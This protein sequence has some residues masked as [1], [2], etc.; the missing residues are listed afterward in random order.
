MQYDVL[1]VVIM[2]SMGIGA[3]TYH[4]MLQFGDW[5]RKRLYRKHLDKIK[6]EEKKHDFR[7]P[8]DGFNGEVID[9][10]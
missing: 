4:F 1:F 7:L 6:K 10:E 5:Y 3:M 9:D 8:K 2:A